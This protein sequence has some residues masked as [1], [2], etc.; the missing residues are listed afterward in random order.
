[1]NKQTTITIL[2]AVADTFS[3]LPRA[4]LCHF[5]TFAKQN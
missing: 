5:R 3:V 2:L 1:M 4:F